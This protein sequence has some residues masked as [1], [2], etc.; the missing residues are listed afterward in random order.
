MFRQVLFTGLFIAAGVLAEAG[1]ES[2][3]Y[4]VVGSGPGGAPLAANLARAGYSVTL[5]EA[6]VDL[7]N[8]K[9]YSELANF[10]A[11]GNDEKSRWDFFVRHS[12]DEAREAKYEKTTWRTADGGFYVGL[13]PPEG[14][15]RLGIYYPRAA[16]LGGC[17]MHNGG[18]C[19]LPNDAD[20]NY[21]AE[22]TG[23]DGWLASNMRKY[24][25]KS[26]LKNGT[27]PLLSCPISIGF[28][29]LIVRHGSP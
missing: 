8:N 14:A 2:Y 1:A 16:T 26:K 18:I 23:D 10:I 9:N 7:G 24:F 6:G 19:T 27:S 4:I 17:A 11:A 29:L 15:K 20:W 28:G 13:D 21:I 3:D 22:S 12:D 25:E 5:L